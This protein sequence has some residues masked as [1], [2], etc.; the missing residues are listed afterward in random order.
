VVLGAIA[1]FGATVIRN[2]R[3]EAP[4]LDPRLVLVLP[5]SNLTGN[6]EL[7]R[8]GNMAAD[9]ISQGLAET[10]ILRVVATIPIGANTETNPAIAAAEAGSLRQ[11]GTTVSGSFYSVGDSVAFQAQVIESTSGE[12]LTSIGPV[13]AS[14][15]DPRAGVEVLRQRTT[16][17]LASVVDPL[18]AS[19]VTATRL[20]PSYEAYQLFA[21]GFDAFFGSARPWDWDIA[22][23]L[24]A[25]DYFHRAADL[26]S[27]YVLPLLW[28]VYARRT[29]NDREGA[30]STLDDLTDRRDRMT[31]WE[32]NLLDALLPRQRDVLKRYAALSR[33]V[34]MTPGSEWNFRLA[35]VAALF[36]RYEEVVTL[37]DGI[38]DP[39]WL[40][41][42]SP[43]WWLLI[44]ARHFTGQYEREIQAVRSWRVRFP[45]AV[46]SDTEVAPLA[47]L[48]RVEEALGLARTPGDFVLLVSELFNHGQHEAAQ[49]VIRNHLPKV[50]L[51]DPSLL[52]PRREARLLSWTGRLAEAESLLVPHL[53]ANPTDWD[54]WRV[55]VE[56]MLAKG[57]REE[58][59]RIS[60]HVA[61][62]DT[63]S[64]P[65][66]AIGQAMIL[67]HLGDRAGAVELMRT[68]YGENRWPEQLLLRLHK[69]GQVP[70]S[71]ANYAPFQELVGWP[72]PAPN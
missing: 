2:G 29:G 69:N 18:L 39:G 65:L 59:V 17:A 50:D 15:L 9:W 48:G 5:F 23:F 42:W 72:P 64:P 71:M 8:L 4:D 25:A 3:S 55:L 47:A 33:L 30:S 11:A 22:G 45:E 54:G 38:T 49:N 66:K 57:D 51:S 63:R 43:Y 58:A 41:A 27:T 16:G 46:W 40:D 67:M 35:E 6:P 14:V 1:A 24:S 53:E 19:W 12:V 68:L 61:E 7:E 44:Q 31:R 62:L 21:Q 32:Q 70:Q 37:L 36:G 13:L 34:A 28:E 60:N 56:V 20:P 26:D 52:H 10:G